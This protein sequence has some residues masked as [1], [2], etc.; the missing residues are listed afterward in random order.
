MIPHIRP[1]SPKISGN[2]HGRKGPENIC[3]WVRR[4]TGESLGCEK[5]AMRR[6]KVIRQCHRHLFGMSG[7]GIACPFTL[8]P[9]TFQFGSRTTRAYPATE[10][11][12]SHRDDLALA[13]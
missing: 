13:E 7:V 3:A 8:T 11:R 12:G 5:L 9:T 4:T 2:D 6:H 1:G 10:R